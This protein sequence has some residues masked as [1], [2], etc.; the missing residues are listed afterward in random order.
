MLINIQLK[1]IESDNMMN[2]KYC[3]DNL[4]LIK[5]SQSYIYK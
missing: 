2:Y 4:S 3:P 1:Q 5:C